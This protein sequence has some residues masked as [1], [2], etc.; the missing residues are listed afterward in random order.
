ML[1]L[2]QNEMFEA[3]IRNSF[4]NGRYLREL[5]LAASEVEY[6]RKIFPNAYIKAIS[7]T[8]LSDKTWYEVNLKNVHINSSSKSPAIQ[9]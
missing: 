8:D 5:R 7:E 9:K 6:V 1:K 4:I 3:F 2:T